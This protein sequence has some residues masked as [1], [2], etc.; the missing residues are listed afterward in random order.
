[1]YKIV[2]TGAAG[3]IGSNLI[4]NLLN[5]G[6]QVFGIDNFC[7]GNSENLSQALKNP[8]F[9]FFEGD[10][11]DKFLL[12]KMMNGAFAVYHQAAIVSVPLCTESPD[13]AVSVNIDGFTKVLMSA[14]QA[15]VQR[16]F[17]ASSCAIYGDQGETAIAEEAPLCPMSLYAVTKEANEKIAFCLSKAFGITTHGMRYFNVYG[18]RQDP[19][20]PY[21]GVIA[22]FIELV[23]TQTKPTIWGSG[24]QTRDFVHVSDLTKVLS[25]MLALTNEQAKEYKVLNIASGQSRT[26]LDLWKII[27]HAIKVNDHDQWANPE[28]KERRAN[29]IIHSKANLDKLQKMFQ[30]INQQYSPM[31]LEQGI[32][33]LL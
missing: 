30:E 26:I 28:F 16:F 15:K 13:L 4:D 9:T 33:H 2:V 6:H 31:A 24:K 11:R 7:S 3:F 18:K 20:G 14:I 22:K 5:L 25:S 12:D 23:K 32:Y 1:M 10:I 21:A 27:T 19:T 17:F 8:N 29:D